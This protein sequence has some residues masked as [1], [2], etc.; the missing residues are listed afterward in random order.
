[1]TLPLQDKVALVTGAGRGLG[2]SCAVMLAARGAKVIVATQTPANGEETVRE[3]K[4]SGGE[5]TFVRAD[6]AREEDVQHMVR[7]AV[8]TY[9]RLDC[10]VNNAYRNI[11]PQ[12]LANISLAD[13]TKAMDVNLTGVFLSMKYEIEAMLAQQGGGAIV[14]IGSGNEHTAL[15]GHSWYLAAKQGIYAMTKVAALDYGSR[16]LRINAVA[17]GP[18]WTPSLRDMAKAEPAHAERLAGRV[19]LGRV[20]EPEEVAEAV[21]WLC[22]SAASYVHGVT[23]SVDGGFVLG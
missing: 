19:P 13:W 20:A 5:A 6:V 1:M 14:N 21:T 7:A 18:M 22:G 12:P 23:L 2:R 17:P 4:A 3:I 11:G 10:A 16:G 15:P 9:G 8:E